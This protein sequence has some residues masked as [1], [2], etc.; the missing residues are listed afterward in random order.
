MNL[1]FA[2]AS[3]DAA[4]HFGGINQFPDIAMGIAEMN[5]VVRP[6]GRVLIGDE[7]IALWLKGTELGNMLIENNPLYA[8]APPLEALPETARDVN[9]SWELC[10]CFWVID[11][12]VSNRPLPVNIDVP[13][14]GKRG[15]SIR[16]R[17][18]G[19]LEGITPDLRDK[20]YAKAEQ[21]G[22]SRVSYLESVLRKSLEEK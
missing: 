13:H 3:F 12:C 19:K 2:D 17:Y 16:S 8:H 20:I 5:R 21:L 9:L 1:P 11:Y 7:G 18:F 4:Y 14:A 22:V 6:G 15:G 10:N